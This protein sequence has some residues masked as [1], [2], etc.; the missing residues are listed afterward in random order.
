MNFANRGPAWP[1][2][3]EASHRAEGNGTGSLDFSDSG[4]AEVV[5]QHPAEALT[6]ADCASGSRSWIR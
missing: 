2:R 3:G 1:A 4:G 6:A 5:V